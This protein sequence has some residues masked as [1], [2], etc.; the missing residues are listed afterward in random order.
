[1]KAILVNLVFLPILLFGEG[2]P[3]DENGNLD[4]P[5]LTVALNS[6]QQEEIE[7]LD[8]VTLT[9]EQW[10]TVRKTS[11]NTPKRLNGILPINHNDCTCGIGYSA[12]LLN[13]T[14]LA[15][16]I[17]EQ[18]PEA[19]GWKLKNLK[20]LTLRVDQRGQ[21][22]LDGALTRFPNLIAALKQSEPAPKATKDDPNFWTVGMA[23]INTP[24]FMTPDSSVYAER[25]SQV[26]QILESKG[27]T[28]YG[29][30]PHIASH[31]D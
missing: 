6:S 30:Y 15:L 25:I 22:Y 24:L 4:A 11:P 17:E 2:L 27:W 19:L 1:M 10:Q 3:I 23:S 7:T 20:K 29:S 5:H 26:G 12:V 8:S 21:F 13:K 18:T 31:Q 28:V 9:K 16:F 14:K